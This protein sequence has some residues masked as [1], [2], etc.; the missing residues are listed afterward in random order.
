MCLVFV[1]LCFV[2]QFFHYVGSLMSVGNKRGITADDIWSL[3]QESEAEKLLH[4][5]DG[6]Y[7][8]LGEGATMWKTFLRIHRRKWFLSAFFMLGYV[9]FNL[10]SPI[11]FR[12]FLV[13][14]K[15]DSYE[16]IYYAVGIFVCTLLAT[17]FQNQSLHHVF[18]IGQRMR[19]MAISLVY[20]RAL[21]LNAASMNGLSTGS[22][23]NLMSN[24]SQRFFDL[25]PMVNLIWAAPIQ[26]II[27]TYFL[28]DLLGY[29]A[30]TGVGTLLLVVP[31]QRKIAQRMELLRKEH[32][33]IT[34]ARVNLCSEVLQ[35][36]RVVK[37]FSWEM[38]FFDKLQEFRK[39]EL[40]VVW[41]ELK[42]FCYFIFFMIVA[43]GAATV[44]TFVSYHLL[45]HEITPEIAFPVLR[46]FF[47]ECM[48][49]FCCFGSCCCV[50]ALGTAVVDTADGAAAAV[51]DVC[52]GGVCAVCSMCS[53]FL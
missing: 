11:I 29:A 23:V 52:L 6:C 22:I 7:A 24:D 31:I 14:L 13:S 32:M 34:D 3:K 36:M 42:F 47:F 37:F 50:A 38:A 4:E 17:L 51:V 49:V 43:P 28:F 16:G 46:Y 21:A 19:A 48:L 41:N 25:L 10:A 33:P 45:G 44:V 18:G 12:Y 9:I 26:I 15:T 35:G 27:S 30:L 5:Y 53:D 40:K 20:R 8:A 2:L 39:A 1:P